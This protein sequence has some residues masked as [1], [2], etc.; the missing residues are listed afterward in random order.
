MPFQYLRDR[1]F[2]SVSITVEL[3]LEQKHQL[4]KLNAQT[5]TVKSGI[6]ITVA[7][8]SRKN[9]RCGKQTQYVWWPALHVHQLPFRTSRFASCTL[10][11][12]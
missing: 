1:V 7:T 5:V 12:K 6:G 10:L 8:Y 2:E 4:V 11:T 3:G 9:R